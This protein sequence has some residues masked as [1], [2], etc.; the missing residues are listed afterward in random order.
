MQH[1]NYFGSLTQAST[2]RVGS[3]RGE[4]IHV[5]FKSIL[6]MVL[7]LFPTSDKIIYNVVNSCYWEMSTVTFLDLIVQLLKRTNRS[8]PKLV[9][10]VNL[11]VMYV[12]LILMQH[13]V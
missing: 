10:I 6:P 1:A 8:I 9:L 5:P 12:L 3:F 2:C 11:N 13:M 7:K 4:E